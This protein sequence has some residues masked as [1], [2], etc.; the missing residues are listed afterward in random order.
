[1]I[2]IVQV[3]LIQKEYLYRYDLENRVRMIS[4]HIRKIIEHDIEYKHVSL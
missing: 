2:K 4:F 1:M 3:V